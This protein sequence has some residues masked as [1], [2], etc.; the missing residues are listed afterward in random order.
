MGAAIYVT[1]EEDI[2][3]LDTFMNGKALLKASDQVDA[4]AKSLGVRPLMEFFSIDPDMASE[5]VANDSVQIS[6]RTWFSA[7]EGLKTARALRTHLTANPSLV[8]KQHMVFDDLTDIER[9]LSAASEHSV[10]W[11]FSIDI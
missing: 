6:P 1:F 8:P 7:D 5:F 4:I 2:P 9:L 11:N 3:G 10:R